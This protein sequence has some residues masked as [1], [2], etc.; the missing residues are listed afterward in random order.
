[1]DDDYLCFTCGY[2]LRSLARSAR[3]PECG[4]LI[5]HSMTEA[6]QLERGKG[7][8]R[9]GQLIMAEVLNAGL[10]LMSLAVLGGGL[11]VLQGEMGGTATLFFLLI[12]VVVGG[13]LWIGVRLATIPTDEARWRIHGLAHWCSEARDRAKLIFL[14]TIGATLLMAAGAY[15]RGWLDAP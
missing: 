11:T 4:A 1:M 2:N 12:F 9:R 15:L 13:H 10:G 6:S 3:C 8:W 7:P 14:G 5:L